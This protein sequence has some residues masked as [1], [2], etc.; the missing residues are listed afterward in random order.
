MY[1]NVHRVCHVKLQTFHC[2]ELV[3]HLPHLRVG[4]ELA[5]GGHAVATVSTQRL[6]EGGLIH[7][8]K[9]LAG[10]DIRTRIEASGYV[11]RAS[12]SVT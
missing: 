4:E 5:A 1:L 10:N 3:R 9:Q 7:T 2:L 6:S 8:P 12:A 11:P